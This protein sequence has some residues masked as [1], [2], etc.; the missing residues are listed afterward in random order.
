MNRFYKPLI[1]LF[2]HQYTIITE[3][4]QGGELMNSPKI[5][6]L[7]LRDILYTLLFASLGIILILVLIFMFKPKDRNDTTPTMTYTPG[8]YTSSF[9]FDQQVV[10][11]EVTIFD[12]KVQSVQF[13]DLDPNFKMMN[14]LFEPAMSTI[15]NQ[16]RKKGADED[17][18]P[19]DQSKETTA[20]IMTA[21]NKALLKAKVQD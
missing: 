6:V 15:N 13:L 20:Y 16:L 2:Y 3:G 4:F 21:V 8:I 12:D 10:N 18:K 14:H 7:K 5:V 11:V 9:L 17:V 1:F 19:D